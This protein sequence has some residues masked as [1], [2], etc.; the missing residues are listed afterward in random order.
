MGSRSGFRFE[1]VAGFW[2]QC[3]ISRR[4]SR[5]RSWSGFGISVRGRGCVSR[6]ESGLSFRSGLEVG[7]GFG[8]WDLGWV[9]RNLTPSRFSTTTLKPDSLTPVP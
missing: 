6:Q 1:V 2:V 7:L 4:G 5:S 9:S 8:F 3:Q